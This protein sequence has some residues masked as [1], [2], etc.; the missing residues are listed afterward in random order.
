MANQI[1]EAL[2]ASANRVLL[3]GWET[4]DFEPGSLNIETFQTAVQSLGRPLTSR[5]QTYGFEMLTPTSLEQAEP[6]SQSCVYGLSK[7]PLHT[8]CAHMPLPPRLL[9]MYC[10]EDTQI[11]PTTLLPWHVCLSS[12][13]KSRKNFVSDATFVV[14]NGKNSYY[15]SIFWDDFSN[16]KLDFNCIF[17]ATKSAVQLKKTLLETFSTI[18]KIEVI[19]RPGRILI[20]DN[21]RVLHGR[22][23]ASQSGNRTL[24]RALLRD[25]T[26]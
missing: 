1:V 8:D 14:K 25:F 12:L 2:R 5:H 19:W 11:R 26:L 3:S 16:V 13:A 21:W 24:I 15:T 10:V 18:D 17:P 9:I 22:G 7:F 4:L 23:D 6:A 20:L